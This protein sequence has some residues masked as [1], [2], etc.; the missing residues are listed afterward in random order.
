[1]STE[2]VLRKALDELS[3]VAQSKT[4][5]QERM[6]GVQERIR[7][8]VLQARRAGATWADIGDVLGITRQSAHTT[9]AKLEQP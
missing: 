7:E 8:R 6:R 4:E 3:S 9:Y 5:V 1:M 2:N